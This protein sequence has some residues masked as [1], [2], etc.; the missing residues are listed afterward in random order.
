MSV[1]FQYPG[2]ATSVARLSRVWKLT[3]T[4]SHVSTEM[5]KGYIGLGFNPGHRFVDETN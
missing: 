2:G 1:V 4:C 5:G 3:G